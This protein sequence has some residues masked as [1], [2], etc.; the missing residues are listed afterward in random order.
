VNT[1]D[2]MHAA[3]WDAVEEASELLR[4]GDRDGALRELRAIV[5]R[6]PRN[7]YAHFFLGAAH[8]EAGEFEDARAAYAQ[9]HTHAPGYLG[10]V[11]GLGHALRMLGQLEE[12]TRMGE[13]ALAMGT[14]P[15][16]DPDAHFLLALTLA[17]RGDKARAASHVEAFLASNPEVEARYDAEALLQTLQGRAKPLEED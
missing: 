1:S 8:F 15:A 6:D 10:A 11:V 17:A 16:G 4:E 7:A 2:P 5:D 12:A 14:D 13:Q 3:Q 9:A